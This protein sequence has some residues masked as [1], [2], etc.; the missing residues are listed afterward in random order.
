MRFT[1]RDAMD[2]P[3]KMASVPLKSAQVQAWF[4]RAELLRCEADRC[5]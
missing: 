1:N 2:T 5:W 4:R 3:S